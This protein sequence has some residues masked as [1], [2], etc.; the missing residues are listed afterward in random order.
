MITTINIDGTIIGANHPHYVIAEMS[1]NHKEKIENA[2]KIITEAK[3]MGAHAVKIQ[4]YTADTLT[5]NSD[6]PDF[7]IDSGLWAG[8]SLYELYKSAYTPW[9]WH[10]E[11]FDFARKSEITLF[12][13]PFDSTAVDL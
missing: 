1:A 8:N 13:T 10:Q 4:T 12:S 11:L 5:L 3:K 7:I 6:M 2:F 9:E